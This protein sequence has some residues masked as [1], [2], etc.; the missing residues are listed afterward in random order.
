[1]VVTASWLQLKIHSYEIRVLKFLLQVTL[2]SNNIS[3]IMN[4]HL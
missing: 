2:K 1:M 4:A 3:N